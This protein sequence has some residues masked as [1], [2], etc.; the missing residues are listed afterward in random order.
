MLY[1]KINRQEKTKKSW[2]LPVLTAVC[3]L[4]IG[5]V[6]ALGI[7][8]I[9]Y[10]VQYQNFVSNLSEATYYAYENECLRAEVD[11]QEIRV[12]GANAYDIYTYITVYGSGKQKKLT[13]DETKCILLDYGN[14]TIMRLWKLETIT[15]EGQKRSSLYIELTGEKGYRYSYVT[16]EVSFDAVKIRYLTLKDNEPW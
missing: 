16:D 15:S 5:A 10:H 1:D 3:V 9:L 8:A 7:W 14:G 11:G 12:S 13:A 2:T 4:V 6:V